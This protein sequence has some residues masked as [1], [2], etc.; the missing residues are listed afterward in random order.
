MSETS[1][2]RGDRLFL[3]VA[4]GVL[5]L[6]VACWP[7]ARAL[8]R[9][10]DRTR[11]L[12]HDREVMAWLQHQEVRDGG[13]P[14]AITVREDEEVEIGGETFTPSTGVTVEVTVDED[15]KFCVR[16]SNDHG[17]AT[18]WTCPDEE[19]PPRDPEASYVPPV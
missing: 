19:N 1:E 6:V 8:D 17:D 9:S 10:V 3:Y 18:S 4:L 2:E 16:A 7:L 15:G 5:A 14:V 12:F 13:S 11:P